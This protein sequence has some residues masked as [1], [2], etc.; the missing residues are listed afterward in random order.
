M[1]LDI[2][3]LLDEKPLSALE[4]AQSLDIPLNR[5]H[6]W[7]QILCKLGLL[8]YRTG[9]YCPS[10]VAKE[11]ILNVH[12]QDTW[13]FQARE[14]R[15]L[16]VYVRDLALNISKPMKAWESWDLR[17]VDYIQQIEKDPVYM[18]SFTHK[19][20][21]I[22]RA[23]AEQL[24]NMLD[25]HGVKR[26]LDLGGGSGVV[27]FALLRAQKDLTSV[28]VDME[29]VCR[30]GRLIAMENQ[31]ENRIAYLPTDILKD[32]LP[33]GFDMVML[34]DVGC[35]SENLFYRIHDALNKAGRLVIVDKFATSKT[36]TPPSRLLSAFLK[37]LKS[38]SD[39]VD[40]ITKDVI[41]TRLQH[42]GFRDITSISVPHHDNLPWNI[43]WTMVEARR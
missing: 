13:A 36:S 3:W 43:D 41:E 17:P 34:C 15:D 25:L 24:A 23:L 9:C 37:S 8:E 1:G 32:N 38:P 22:H 20:Y 12:N 2:Y 11:S 10:T 31:L 39:S 5:C 28:V 40:Y 21:Q 42:V 30:V 18:A 14:D 35:F 7:L 26:L 29:S 33:A 4:L 16:T 27:S 6:Y 19:L